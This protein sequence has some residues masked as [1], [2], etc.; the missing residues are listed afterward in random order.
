[1]MCGGC[2]GAPQ[3]WAAELVSGPR[4][5]AAVARRMTAMTT[6][7]RVCA[8]PSGWVVSTPTGRSTVCRTYDELV[9]VVSERSGLDRRMVCAAGLDSAAL[10]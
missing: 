7:D 8:I 5:R 2:A 4:R 1:M 6:H 9:D 3:D 10:R